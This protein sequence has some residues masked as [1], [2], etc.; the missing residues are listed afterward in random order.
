MSATSSPGSR[1]SDGTWH[2]PDP[3]TAAAPP[4]EDG[5]P[6]AIG[7]Y[8]PVALVGAGGMGR[9]FRA[10]AP[11]G[12]FVAVK[13]LHPHLVDEG[14]ARVRLRRE[15]ETMRR[16]RARR[17]AEILEFDVEAPVP[18]IVTR[19]VEGPPLLEVVGDT[20]PLA[21]TALWR[22]ALGTAE[23]LE[24]IHRAGVVHRDIK[25]GNVLLE[26][27]E[28]V[29]IDFGIS[30]GVDDTRLTHGG[31]RSGTWRY[32]APELLEGD[33]AGPPADVFAWAALVAYAATGRDLY[34]APNDAA[35]CVR[36]IRGDHDLSD[37]SEELR[38][39]LAAALASDPA[40]RP[41]AEAL[42]RQLRAL[43]PDSLGM[44]TVS[45]GTG[46]HSGQFSGS[47]TGPQTGPQTGLQT[48]PQTG[49]AADATPARMPA[50]ARPL[51]PIGP[52][53][54]LQRLGRGGMGEVF[55]AR[56]DDGRMVAIKTLHPFL[57]AEFKAKERLRREVEAMRRIRSRH[58]VELV[59]AA[60]DGDPPYIVT[61]YVEGTSLLEA[62]KGR[63]PLPREG[64]LK[65]AG[66]LAGAL[67]AV[68]A[69]QSVHRDINPG[70]VMLVAGEPIVI[71][72]GIAYL[73]GADRLTRGPIGTPGYVAPEA[74]EDAQVGPPADVFAWAATVAYAATGRRAYEATSPA[75]YVRHVLDGVP[76]DLDGIEG[77][78]REVLE[79]ALQRDP[80]ARP[81]AAEL[82]ARF[83][84]PGTIAPRL[85]LR[86][87]EEPK[88]PLPPKPEPPA[89]PPGRDQ[90]VAGGRAA[91]AKAGFHLTVSVI[92][93]SLGDAKRE[94]AAAA[95]AHALGGDWAPHAAGYAGRAL[96][97]AGRA[98]RDAQTGTGVPANG[99]RLAEIIRAAQLY[100]AH[101]R[102]LMAGRA[103]P[104]ARVADVRRALAM[105]DATHFTRVRFK[106]GYDPAEVDAFVA[107]IRIWLSGEHRDLGQVVGA[108]DVRGQT[109]TVRRL[110]ET[111]DRGEVDGFLATME[112]EL[113]RLGYS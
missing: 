47:P 56:A 81:S 26:N 71:D 21:G 98:I 17:V 25:P 53:R 35:V 14:D 45:G 58:V 68:H 106:E 60:V 13:T 43:R 93:V 64:V 97:A 49:P 94:L 73:T 54:P 10:I 55:L 16:V 109:F 23:A 6:D 29:V 22:V 30:Q 78:L 103:L 28:P 75:A 24:A 4:G 12:R 72:F 63:G 92:E 77:D 67:A 2:R 69:A 101:A 66:G 36:I 50:R 5:P 86:R 51:A 100:A 11:E 76:P 33:D 62:V 57:P 61:R 82:A 111:Y 3:A 80:G 65:L 20:G 9:V 88:P 59:D 102:E 38:P 46:P 79:E 44:R 87:P 113:R 34:D 112:T 48:G 7:P 90:L 19:F 89:Q 108:D 18:Y 40:A 95:R 74:L 41:G 39:V 8:R 1:S 15:V 37:I 83:A 27:G 105:L 107:Q 110:R 104:P 99:P 31:G 96:E 32:L 91:F 84:N 85:S 42:V 70:N 52:Y